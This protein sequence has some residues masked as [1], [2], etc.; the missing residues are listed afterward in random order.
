VQTEWSD[1]AKVS[2]R[3]PD[4]AVIEATSLALTAVEVERRG[5]LATAPIVTGLHLAA[6]SA[7][8]HRMVKATPAWAL[9]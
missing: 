3:L 8:P 5:G 7:S 4:A 6:C 2:Q 9:T 1:C